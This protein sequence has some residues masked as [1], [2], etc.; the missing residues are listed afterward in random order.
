MSRWSIYWI[1]RIHQS[2]QMT[3]GL[4]RMHKKSPNI[5][6]DFHRESG[7][8]ER[9]KGC[10]RLKY[11]LFGVHSWWNENERNWIFYRGD[12]VLFSCV[13]FRWCRH[14]V[15]CSRSNIG[16]SGWTPPEWFRRALANGDGSLSRCR[17]ALPDGKNTINMV[18]SFPTFPSSC[19]DSFHEGIP[20]LDSWIVVNFTLSHTVS[21]PS[22]W[23]SLR[24]GRSTAKWCFPATIQLFL[25]FFD[26]SD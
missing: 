2:K 21:A 12:D 26:L 20:Q 15:V 19:V 11:L 5:W 17:F 7:D 24:W 9:R 16:C 8:M 23:W 4:P 18:L 3:R 25:A 14:F 6:D 13:I 22:M 10:K 1:L